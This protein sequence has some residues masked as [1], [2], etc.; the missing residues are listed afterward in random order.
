MPDVPTER[1]QMT[2]Q[3]LT[4]LALILLAALTSYI[5]R[6]SRSLGRDVG[7]SAVAAHVLGDRASPQ[8]VYGD[9]NLTLV[10]FTDYQM[11]GLSDGRSCVTSGGRP[12]RQCACRL[13]GLADLW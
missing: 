1:L 8:E 4:L 13:Q 5:L 11:S 12:R 10:M 2:R 6:S 7:V 9:A 3:L